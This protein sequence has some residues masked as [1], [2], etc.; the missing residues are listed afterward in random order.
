MSKF[1]LVSSFF[2]IGSHIKL[3][4]WLKSNNTTTGNPVA[5][6]SFVLAFGNNFVFAE[7]CLWFRSALD[8]DFRKVMLFETYEK[9]G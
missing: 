8:L 9:D 1:L 4:M 5:E 7:Y 6:T 2:V 3:I